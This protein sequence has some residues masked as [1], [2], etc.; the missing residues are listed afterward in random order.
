[1]F[2]TATDEGRLALP[3]RRVVTLLAFAAVAFVV[4]GISFVDPTVAGLLSDDVD[5]RSISGTIATILGAVAITLIWVEQRRFRHIAQEERRA[6]SAFLAVSGSIVVVLD[7][8]GIVTVANRQ[9]CL[10]LDREEDEIL[11]RD[12]FE[13][14]LPEGHA[15]TARAIYAQ[16]FHPDAN[17]FEG[18]EGYENEIVARSGERRAVTWWGTLLFDRTG[19]PTGM[20][21][22]GTDVTDER[23]AKASLQRGNLE[24]AALRH[25]AQKVAS[26]DD[27]RQAIVDAALEVSGARMAA[28]AEPDRTRETLTYTVGTDESVLGFEIAVRGETSR[29][30]NAFTAGTPQFMGNLTTDPGVHRRLADAAADG[31][32]GSAL[33]QPII[34][35]D[36]T[37][38]VLSVAW[39]HHLDSLQDRKALLIG[40]VAHEASIALR[41]RE[42]LAQ[43]ARAALV[44][45][46]TGI[47][48][49]RAF[50]AELP[51]AL[52]RAAEA[53]HGLSLVVMDLNEFKAV[54]D[55]LGHEAGDDVLIRA[56][57]A[58]ADALRAGDLLARLGGDEFAVLLPTCDQPEMAQIIDRLRRATP[59]GPGTSVGGAIWDG[60]ETAASLIRRADA[61]QYVDKARGRSR[62]RSR[63]LAEDRR[64]PVLMPESWHE[65]GRMRP[66]FEDPRTDD[67]GD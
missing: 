30:G 28:I 64:Q 57:T 27:A 46:L 17:I 18:N 47:A 65:G 7:A 6:A 60:T 25:L 16:G 19:R 50:D 35:A 53:G 48:N 1:M 29:V 42:S 55:V 58:W 24:L 20:V 22:A 51:L 26:L 21:C 5:P 32:A 14:A 44:D 13:L 23:A 31:N 39:D 45:P 54:N 3:H 36:G 52:R 9:A 40:L 67:P 41:R 15:A 37:V 38:G 4:T 34:G 11:G 63:E 59:H 33:H 56:A 62:G 43:L 49:R 61:E 2:G 10:V 12:W 66:R 8:K